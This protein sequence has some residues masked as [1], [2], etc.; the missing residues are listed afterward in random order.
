MIPTECLS[1]LTKKNYEKHRGVL[2]G[3]QPPMI[4]TTF[5][6]HIYIN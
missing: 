5:V 4:Q 2:G 6:F 3:A 1:L